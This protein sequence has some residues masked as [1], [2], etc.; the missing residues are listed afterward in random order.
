MNK[1]YLLLSEWNENISLQDF[2]CAALAHQKASKKIKKVLPALCMLYWVLLQQVIR[3]LGRGYQLWWEINVVVKQL[4][5]DS[6]V[7]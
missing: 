1:P 4:L 3:S 7:N 6:C 5:T 2:G